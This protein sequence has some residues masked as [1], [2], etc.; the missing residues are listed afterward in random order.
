MNPLI[1]TPN[2]LDHYCTSVCGLVVFCLLRVFQETFNFQ[3]LCCF[4]ETRNVILRHDSFPGIH[5]LIKEKKLC[6]LRNLLKYMFYL[7]KIIQFF[8]IDILQDNYWMLVKVY[9]R[10]SSLKPVGAGWQ[11]FLVTLQSL[12]VCWESYVAEQFFI[13]I[14]PGNI[15][16]LF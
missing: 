15:S 14:F 13:Q 16:R 1:R 10:Q 6:F 2:R 3:H 11:N 12:P 7:N 5:K 9:R 8:E 4:Q